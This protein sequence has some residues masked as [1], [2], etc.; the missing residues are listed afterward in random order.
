MP[1]VVLA[2]GMPQRSELKGLF[3][4]MQYI[5]CVPAGALQRTEQGSGTLSQ[6]H[7]VIS[8]V[9][10][11]RGMVSEHFIQSQWQSEL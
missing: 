1:P 4:Q 6:V 2:S 8:A 10:V 11:R 3:T 5:T 9:L 7:Q